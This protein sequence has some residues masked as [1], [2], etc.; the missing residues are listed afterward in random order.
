MCKFIG[1]EVMEIYVDASLKN[2]EERTF[3]C[4][5]VLCTNTHEEKY[6]VSQDSTNNRGE[7][8]A[9]YMGC[10]MANKNMLAEPD[11]YARINLYSDSQFVIFGLRKWMSGWLNN[12]DSKGIMYGSTGKPVK[13]QEMFKMIISFCV[14]NK[15][16]IHFYNQR[17][18]TN[19]NSP[20][21]LAMANN[22]FLRANGVMLPPEDIW[23]I[24][25]YNDI[26]DKN[27]RAMLENLNPADYPI[28][29][30]NPNAVQMCHY[31]VPAD[32]SAY[33]K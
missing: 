4:S 3:T 12:C 25:F 20:R 1:K 30:H 5:G 28:F 32:Y 33:I 6:V 21:D 9:V 22:Q 26:V 10:C 17:G 29:H 16:I 14:I 2:I 7:L 27:S 23:K 18:H 15:L 11:R 31:V 13:N 19:I 8:L 24:S